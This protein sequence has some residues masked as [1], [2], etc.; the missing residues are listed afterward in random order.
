MESVFNFIN[1]Q[2]PIS[3]AIHRG[4]YIQKTH[5]PVSKVVDRQ[6]T[7]HSNIDHHN[8]ARICPYILH[9]RLYGLKPAQN[10]VFALFIKHSVNRI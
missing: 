2:N 7:I 6:E 8:T 1:H 3:N 10:Y 5:Y 4:Q 9:F